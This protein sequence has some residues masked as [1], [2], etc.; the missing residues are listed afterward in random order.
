MKNLLTII[1]I[2]LLT[3][4][5]KAQT[6]V[7]SAFYS[8]P[9]NV[10]SYAPETLRMDMVDYYKSGSTRLV[11]NAFLDGSRILEL[12]EQSITIQETADSAA[13]AQISL[14]FT[15][16]LKYKSMRH[17]INVVSKS[18]FI[19]MSN[20]TKR[21]RRKFRTSIWKKGEFIKK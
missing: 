17:S 2:L 12:T 11:Q 20:K 10:I 16:D 18:N 6:S 5:A 15:G 8:A 3:V 14:G 4:A 21:I 9:D 1:S 7:E 19:E 13:I